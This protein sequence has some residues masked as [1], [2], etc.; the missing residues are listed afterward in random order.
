MIRNNKT[1]DSRMRKEEPHF[2]IVHINNS[3]CAAVLQSH[4]TLITNHV[5]GR[6]RHCTLRIW[7]NCCRDLNASSEHGGRL[8]QSLDLI[9]RQDSQ[10]KNFC[11]IFAA[12]YSLPCVFV[13]LRTLYLLVTDLINLCVVWSMVN[14]LPNLYNLG[15]MN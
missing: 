15:R 8:T 13:H 11:H 2:T 14:W 9:L 10:R 6:C 12:V 3:V 4:K 5:R 1:L 7:S